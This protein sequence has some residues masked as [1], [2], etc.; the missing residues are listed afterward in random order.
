[1]TALKSK[2][3]E[4]KIALVTGA[5]DPTIGL[6]IARGLARAGA[7]VMMADHD[8]SRLDAAA[9]PLLAADLPIL[10]QKI[11]PSEEGDWQAAIDRLRSHWGGL[12]ILIHAASSV[13]LKDIE[14][15]SYDEWKKVRSINL[16]GVFIGSKVAL[17][18]LKE[19]RAGAIILLSP[20]D[21]TPAHARLPSYYISKSPT[22]TFAKALALHCELKGYSVRCNA[23]RPTFRNPKDAL[24]LLNRMDTEPELINNKLR[25]MIPLGQPGRGDEALEAIIF[26]ASD[27][28]KAING[29]ELLLEGILAPFDA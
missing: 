17:G 4:G 25:D 1:M 28:A 14:Q 22:P 13:F 29:K 15:L 12:D 20:W 2:R 18:L 26:L 27:A 24:E 23:I 19:S 6:H 10:K 9:A 7:H 21:D 5:G 3:L 11:D 16:D 8:A